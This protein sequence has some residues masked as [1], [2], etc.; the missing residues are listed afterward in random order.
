MIIIEVTTLLVICIFRP[1]QSRA[2]NVLDGF[3]SLARLACLAI[4]ITFL[5]QLDVNRIVVTVLGIV[6]LVIQ[7]VVILV[8]FVNLLIQ[9]GKCSFLELA[10]SFSLVQNTSPSYHALLLWLKRVKQG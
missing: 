10:F 3:L 2:S 7:S 6:I 9:I 8:L 4:L 5:E 1:Y